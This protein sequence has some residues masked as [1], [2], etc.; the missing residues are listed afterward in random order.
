[1]PILRYELGDY[2]EAGAPCPCGRGLDVLSRMVGRARDFVL[3]PN[4]DRRFAW[5]SPYVLAEIEPV[6]Q[7]QIAQV[8]REEM[9][10]RMVAT[11]P[12]TPAEEAKFADSFIANW[13]YPFRFRFAY[14]D[15]IP[16]V[17]RGKYF[18]FRSELPSSERPG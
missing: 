2:A 13:G 15:S 14:R 7:Y 10:V 4:G 5:Q 3:L 6:V 8:S 17:G 18:V 12:L 11:R 16:R 9:E 1:M